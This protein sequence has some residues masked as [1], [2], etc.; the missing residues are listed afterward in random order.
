MKL[1]GVFSNASGHTIRVVFTRTGS[2]EAGFT[3]A[4]LL[5]LASGHWTV[6]T[7]EL[8]RRTAFEHILDALPATPIRVDS[9]LFSAEAERVALFITALAREAT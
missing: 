2:H 5:Q 8:T 9:D 4:C 6:R 1:F 7:A 3:A